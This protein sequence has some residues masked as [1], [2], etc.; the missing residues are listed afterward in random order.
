[1]EL[2]VGNAA[3]AKPSEIA[4]LTALAGRHYCQWKTPIE[5]CLSVHDLID[6]NGGVIGESVIQPM[7]AWSP[8]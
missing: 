8:T 6:Q 5:R 2:V 4:R 3:E 7:A 1:M